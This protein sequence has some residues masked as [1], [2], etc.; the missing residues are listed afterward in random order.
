MHA[1]P[2]LPYDRDGVDKQNLEINRY[3]DDR[4]LYLYS[5]SRGRLG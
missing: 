5:K 4:Q 3:A 2:F 1:P